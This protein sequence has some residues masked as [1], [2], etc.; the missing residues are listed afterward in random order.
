MSMT[1]DEA[2]KLAL[3]EV[4]IAM[5]SIPAFGGGCFFFEHHDSEYISTAIVDPMAVTQALHNR[6][7]VIEE[8][9]NK[10]LAQPEQEP[11][12]TARPGCDPAPKGVTGD[13]C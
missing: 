3:D 6:L 8:H 11:A 7:R 13:A 5:Q 12:C 1:K 9:L 2:L 10:A 4:K